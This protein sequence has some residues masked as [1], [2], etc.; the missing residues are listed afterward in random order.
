KPEILF[1]RIHD[2]RERGYRERAITGADNSFVRFERLYSDTDSRLARVALTPD[3]RLANLWQNARD[4]RTAWQ[5]IRKEVERTQRSV[6]SVS[7]NVFD[8]AEDVEVMAFMRTLMQ[9][10]PRPDAT[11]TR[12]AQRKGKSKIWT[13]QQ[14]DIDEGS[15]L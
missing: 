8:R 1:I 5:E 14:S 10:W 4:P 12:I 11:V 7:G 3:R 9:K 13:D 15:T 2:G 6:F